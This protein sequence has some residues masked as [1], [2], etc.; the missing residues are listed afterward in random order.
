MSA[1]TTVPATPCSWHRPSTLP[2]IAFH[3]DAERR[4]EAGE[5]Q[6]LCADC[7]RWLWED[8][9]GEAPPGGPLWESAREAAG[10]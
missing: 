6:R 5:R 3:V 10:G 1:T 7:R 8:E 9:W 4:T 2:Y